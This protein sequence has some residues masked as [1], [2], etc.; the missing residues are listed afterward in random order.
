M[1]RKCPE[2]NLDK[3]LLVWGM[4]ILRKKVGNYYKRSRRFSAAGKEEDLVS[5]TGRCGVFDISQESRVRHTELHAIVNALIQALPPAE[6]AA[7]EL[8]VM[9]LPTREIAEELSPERYQNVANR[10][11][12]GRKKLARELARYGYGPVREAHLSQKA[13]RRKHQAS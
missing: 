11:Y 1:T 3:G 2:G 12:R 7:M 8:L 6:R 9:G 10:L 5:E 4:G 13:R